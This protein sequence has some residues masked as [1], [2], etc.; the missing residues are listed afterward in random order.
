MPTK[1]KRCAFQDTKAARARDTPSYVAKDC[2]GTIKPGK[3]KAA[4]GGPQ[5]YVSRAKVQCAQKP[6]FGCRA[7]WK[8]VEYEV[9]PRAKTTCEFQDTKS[10]RARDTPSYNAK[11]C[12]WLVRPGKKKG[13]GGGPKKYMSTPTRRC[14]SRLGCRYIWKWIAQ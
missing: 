3:I 8:W 7:V 14:S 13:G 2:Q 9:K 11:E 10:M 4:D 5:L 6:P 1:K 12:P